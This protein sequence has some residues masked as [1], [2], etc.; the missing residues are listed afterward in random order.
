MKKIIALLLLCFVITNCEKDDICSSD[1]GTTPKLIL[2]FYD[3]SDEDETK[4]VPNLLV[5]GIDDSNEPVLFDHIGL[6]AA[7]KDSIAIPLRTDGNATRFVLHRD[8]EGDSDTGNIDI[9][10]ANYIGENIYV[11]RACGYK[12]I[13]NA[14][15]LDLEPDSDNW[16]INSEI[17]NTTV[18]NETTAHVKIYH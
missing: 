6:T 12:T 10:T 18:E 15:A 5:Y 3:I 2:R 13:Y 16:V 1:T 8:Y 4:Q 17:I 9:I 14:L 7:N 11:S